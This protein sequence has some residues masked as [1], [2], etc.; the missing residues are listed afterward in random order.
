MI[1]LARDPLRRIQGALVVV[2]ALFAAAVPGASRATILLAAPVA[3][4]PVVNALIDDWQ[5]AGG[6]AIKVDYGDS[7]DQAIEIEMNARPYDLIIAADPHA[8]FRV[9]S[10]QLIGNPEP[11]ASS[12]LVLVVTDHDP[13][14]G[15]AADLAGLPGSERVAVADPQSDGVGVATRDVLSQEGRWEMHG[16]A[17]CGIALRA[18]LTAG[19][20]LHEIGSPL[21]DAAAPQ[22]TYMAAPVAARRRD[23]VLRFIGFLHSSQAA[24]TMLSR[25]FAPERGE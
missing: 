9:L 5:A 12:P 24:R 15:S 4:A 23:E 18:D 8:I 22:V 20:Q 19:D 11:L 13:P 17:C 7:D 16:E 21:V 10:K 25:G 3:W 1:G 2:A 14:I 6:G